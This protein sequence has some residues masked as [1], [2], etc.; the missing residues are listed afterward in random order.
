MMPKKTR[1][2]RK[3][4]NSRRKKT[5]GTNKIETIQNLIDF[6]NSGK[7][8]YSKQDIKKIFDEHK[9]LHFSFHLE[10]IDLFGNDNIKDYNDNIVDYIW[11]NILSKLKKPLQ[12]YYFKADGNRKDENGKKLRRATHYENIKRTIKKNIH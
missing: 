10:A 11:D 9:N 3:K 6:L 8:K 1:H 2:Q 12:R 7:G 5:G 4:K